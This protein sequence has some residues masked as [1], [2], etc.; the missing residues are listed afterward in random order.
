M[1][2]S[3]LIETYK[4][5][6]IFYQ[7][8]LIDHIRQLI[9]GSRR[10]SVDMELEDFIRN[11]KFMAKG[12]LIRQLYSKKIPHEQL[13]VILNHLIEEACCDLSKPT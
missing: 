4:I 12:F 11:P 9:I 8:K 3:K 6:A 5:D 13:E 2:P 1:M 7:R 10:T